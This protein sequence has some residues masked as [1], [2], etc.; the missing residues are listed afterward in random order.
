MIRGLTLDGAIIG[1]KY[2]LLPDWKLLADPTVWV[3][4]AIQNFNSI[5]VGFGGV[6]SLSSYKKKD[7][8]IL[9]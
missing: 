2:F 7:K 1:I 8:K 9:K 4:A 3:F 5:G 6:I